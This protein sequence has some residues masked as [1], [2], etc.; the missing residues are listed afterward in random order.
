MRICIQSPD[1]RGDID[2]TIYGNTLR[3]LPNQVDLSQ[4]DVV[5]VPISRLPGYTFNPALNA[6]HQ[7]VVIV[8]FIEYEWSW[9]EPDTHILGRNTKS[10]RWLND[11]AWHQLDDWAASR[12]IVMYFKRELLQKDVTPRIKPIE[13]ACYLPGGHLHSKEEFNHRALEVF[14]TWGY[15]HQIRAEMHADI[16]RGINHNSLAVVSEFEHYDKYFASG[17]HWRT[18]MSVFTPHFARRNIHDLMRFQ[19]NAKLT[20]SLPGCG[21]KCFRST[22][23]PVS[24]IMALQEDNLAWSFDWVD[25]KNCIRL[26]K[27]EE[28]AALDRAT[29]RDDLFEIYMGS[30]ETIDR[31]RSSRYMNEYIVPLIQG[32]L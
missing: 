28:F 12:N 23:A 26:P 21:Q 4:A 16:F 27:G 30:L 19:E 32:A 24:S 13:W 17:A 14:F 22:E 7:P 15:S 1:A 3:F 29:R 6:V 2:P 11:P 20:V 18:W 8:D 5:V 25:G 9:N 10:C 31:Y